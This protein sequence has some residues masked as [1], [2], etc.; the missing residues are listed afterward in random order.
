MKIF[1]FGYISIQMLMRGRR[2]NFGQKALSIDKKCFSKPT[3]DVRTNKKSSHAGKLP[4]G[5]AHVTVK[6]LGNKKLGM[7]LHRYIMALMDRV[8]MLH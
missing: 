1:E 2:Y 5:T 4:Y 7:Y 3:V 8:F 6:G